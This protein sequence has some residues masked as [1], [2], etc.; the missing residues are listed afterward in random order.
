M[1]TIIA[2]VDVC[3]SIVIGGVASC[4]RAIE[5]AEVFGEDILNFYFRIINFLKTNV[6]G[7]NL[8]SYS[9]LCGIL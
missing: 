8:I 4:Q 5:G 3:F 2:L 7:C 6:T 9:A 1:S